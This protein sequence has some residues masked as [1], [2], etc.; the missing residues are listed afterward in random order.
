V[1]DCA[2]SKRQESDARYIEI[3]S[4][5]LRKLAHRGAEFQGENFSY[6]WSWRPLV[7]RPIVFFRIIFAN[8]YRIG[9]LTKKW[10]VVVL[11]GTQ[12]N[13][14]PGSLGAFFL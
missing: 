3:Y 6:G 8:V 2:V 7:L 12:E 11:I 10:E 13:D 1:V 4:I 5:M 14:C 9:G